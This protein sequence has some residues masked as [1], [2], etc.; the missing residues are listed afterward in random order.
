MTQ[1]TCIETAYV[2]WLSREAD[3]AEATV[4]E[5]ALKSAVVSLSAA[6][7][8]ELAGAPP[9]PDRIARACTAS[10]ARALATVRVA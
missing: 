7:P 8:E 4:A 9:A 3:L 5:M 6:G 1:V 2:A 10:H